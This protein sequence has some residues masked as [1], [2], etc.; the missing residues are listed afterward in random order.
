MSKSS[1]SNEA[2]SEKKLSIIVPIYNVEGYVRQCVESIFRQG[3]DE[4]DYEVIFVNDG[5]TDDS[6]GRIAD[7]ISQHSNISVMAQANQGLSVARNNGIA[8]AK[9]EYIL[10]PDSDDLLIDGSL[11]LLLEKALESKVDLVVADFIEA[12]EGDA[13]TPEEVCW[14]TINPEPQDALSKETTGRELFLEDLNPNEC[15]V[16]R[17]LYRRAFLREQDI[18]FVPGIRYQDVP[19]THECYLKAGRCLRVH[20]LLNVYRRQRLGATTTGFDMSKAYDFCIAIGH[21]WK[22]TAIDWL[23]T[24][25]RQ[26]LELD[27]Y[28]SFIALV[29]STIYAVEN[30]NDR[31]SIMR[32][33]IQ[34]APDIRFRGSMKKRL[35]TFL[36]R[37]APALLL[38]LKKKH[39]LW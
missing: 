9:G 18:T 13:V 30:K 12:I 17:T 6:L 38:F 28:T 8:K 15:Y 35:E 39:R 19:Y 29:Y 22:L 21:T 1:T 16:W 7:I 3:L 4:N 2:S 36:L 10:M 32:F 33:L 24:A 23:T 27:V 14:K 25:E 37:H 34:Q 11:P 26:K 31:L 20:W 5:T